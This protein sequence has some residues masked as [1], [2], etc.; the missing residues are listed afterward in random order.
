MQIILKII[1]FS[2]SMILVNLTLPWWGFILS[3]ITIPW[4]INTFKESI[5]V[6]TISGVVSWIPL[7]IFNYLNGGEILY[8][9]ISDMLGVSFPILLIFNS[10]IIVCILSALS[11][12]V[13]F[14][15]KRIIDDKNH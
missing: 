12:S 10:G 13:S 15:F 7:L 9:R 8:I 1:L 5:I 14:Y 2:I 11:V 3:A 6:S 4:F